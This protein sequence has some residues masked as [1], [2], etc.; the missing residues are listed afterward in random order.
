MSLFF[1]KISPSFEEESKE[2]GKEEV[3]K[4]VLLFIKEDERLCLS[5]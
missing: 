2:E 3:E 5:V 4:G 1:F